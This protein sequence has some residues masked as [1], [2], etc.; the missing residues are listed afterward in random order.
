MKAK[1]TAPKMPK[2][3][4]IIPL[5]PPHRIQLSRS[6]LNNVDFVLY[7]QINGS[8]PENLGHT[9]IP[10]LIL[11]QIL[12]QISADIALTPI[13]LNALVQRVKSVTPHLK[14]IK[15]KTANIALNLSQKGSKKEAKIHQN[16]YSSRMDKVAT[17]LFPKLASKYPGMYCDYLKQKVTLNNNFP[18]RSFLTVYPCF[19]SKKDPMGSKID[20]LGL[21]P[22]FNGLR[23]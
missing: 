11:I 1:S 12:I 6:L 23:G 2:S 7:L 15:I 14:Q 8:N 4:K 9:H 22:A 3:P 13:I 18:N 16:E 10:K 19:F 21:R 5:N 20:T 17:G